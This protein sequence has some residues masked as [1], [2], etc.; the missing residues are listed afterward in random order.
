MI[1][2][3]NKNTE[4]FSTWKQSI[5]ESGAAVLIDKAKDWTSFDVCA[6][7]RGMMKTKKVGHAGTLDPLATGLLIVCL[8][9]ATKNIDSFQDMKKGYRTLIKLGA[10]TKTNDAAQEEENIKEF[11][12]ITNEQIESALKS[13]VGVSLQKPPMY[14]ARK[15]QG[16]RLYELAR[17]NIEV[18]VEPRQIEIYD[19]EIHSIE[20]PFIDVSLS[21]SKG[22]YIR[23]IARDLGI[24]LGTG[25]YLADLRRTFIGEYNAD[26]AL[27]LED[28]QTLVNSENE[29]L[30]QN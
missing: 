1:I 24:L 3:T 7:L 28:I 2:L 6:K 23:A 20:L 4:E 8:G 21:T 10:T 16:K 17:K 25:A 30:P 14:S 12:Q 29:S 22:T 9:K 11:S 5:F 26:D 13:F 15:I 27:K 18:E 19:I